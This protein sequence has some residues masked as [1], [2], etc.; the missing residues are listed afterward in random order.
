MSENENPTDDPKQKEHTITEGATIKVVKGMPKY[1]ED[2]AKTPLG[3]SDID[4]LLLNT[5]PVCNYDCRKCFTTANG[6]KP[7]NPLT[8]EEWRRLISQGAELGAKNVSILGEGEP[9]IY[10][11]IRKVIGH[12]NDEG[13][14]PM[15]ATNARELDPEMADFLFDNNASVGFSLDTLN[16]DEYNDFCRGNANFHEV[17]KNIEYARKRFAQAIETQEGFRMHRLLLH[18][19]VTPQNFHLFQQMEEFCGDDIYFDPQPLA[20]VGEAEGQGDYFGQEQNYAKYQRDGHRLYPP[21]VLTQTTDGRDICCLFYLGISIN[22]SGDVMF[23][24]HSIEPEKFIGNVRDVPLPK[25]LER[26]SKLRSYFMENYRTGYCPI[27]D[28]S[29]KAFLASLNQRIKD[30]LWG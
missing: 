26:L 25:L 13:M 17:M 6:R 8:F 18:M 1:F 19:T 23:D 7:E 2:V 5:P 10:P 22:H 30:L 21:M 28:E 9:L 20:N 15:I 14:I 4:F 16:A 24:T 29:Y 11:P 27:R 3:V 12:I